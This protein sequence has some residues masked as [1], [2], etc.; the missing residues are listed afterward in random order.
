MYTTHV[1]TKCPKC[2]GTGKIH[3]ASCYGEGCFACNG[4]GKLATKVQKEGKQPDF[5][6]H[7]YLVHPVSTNI[8]VVTFEGVPQRYT[9]K[10]D[11][12]LGRKRWHDAEGTPVEYSAGRLYD[13]LNANR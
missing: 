8:R 11:A 10:Q 1:T 9:F 3:F 2:Q 6:I 12:R 13:A 5:T 4:S 7:G